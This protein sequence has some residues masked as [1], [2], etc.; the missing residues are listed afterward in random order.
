MR[1]RGENKCCGSSDDT[2]FVGCSKKKKERELG[3]TVCL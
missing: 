1:S 2:V 3:A